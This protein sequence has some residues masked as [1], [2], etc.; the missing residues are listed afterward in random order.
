MQVQ[1]NIV[2]FLAG[3]PPQFDLQVSNPDAETL[4]VEVE[5]LQVLNPGTEEELRELV[6]NP[7]DAD[8]LVTPNRF[9]LPPKNRKIIRLVNIGGHSSEERVFRINLKPIPP[10]SEASQNAI[11]IH[12]AYQVLALI[13]PE[14][15]NSDL[16]IERKGTS[17]VAKNHGNVNALLRNG[18]QC[19][20][21]Q[22]LDNRTESQCQ[23]IKARRIYPGNEWKTEL[24]YDTPVEF[25]VS[26]L[27]RNR[28]QRF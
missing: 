1:Q 15:P 17:L 27:G 14:K 12:V 10:P 26:E 16:Q 2:H 19:T 28:R 6:K 20:T 9:I 3:Q 18:V 4:Y 7:L 21:E 8:F 24:P 22:N 13:S 5:V 23:G 11:R 25:V